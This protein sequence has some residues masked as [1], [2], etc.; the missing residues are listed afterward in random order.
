MARITRVTEPKPR[1]GRTSPGTLVV[2][3]VSDATGRTARRALDAALAQFPGVAVQVRQVGAVRTPEAV[4][5]V[6]EQA[7]GAGAAIVHTFVLADLRRHMYEAAKQRGVHAIDIMGPLLVHLQAVLGRPPVGLPGGL[8]D[9]SADRA[10]AMNFTVK[11]D[12]GQRPADL[13]TADLVLIGPSRTSKTP[14][15]VYLS[16]YGWRVA[17]VPILLHAPPPESLFA[18]Q[19]GRVVGLTATSDDLQSRRHARIRRLGV[20]L[21]GY[22]DP[23]AIRQ[24]LSLLLDLCR[25]HD[26]RVVNVS[27]RSIEETAVEI[28]DIVG[29]L[30]SAPA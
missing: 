7:R 27:D 12:D 13:P 24:E 26:W 28:L 20:A 30:R 25:R 8:E 1:A 29:Q 18:V 3:A 23:R 6:A 5:A 2:Y 15:S 11:H 9:E 16:Y 21:P 14:L 22:T 10:A 19:K 4:E 17:N